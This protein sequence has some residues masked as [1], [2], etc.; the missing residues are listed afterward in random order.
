MRALLLV[1]VC[2]CGFIPALHAFTS[3]SINSREVLV[4]GKQTSIQTITY[5]ASSLDT[6]GTFQIGQCTGT[7]YANP[8]QYNYALQTVGNV[9]QSVI[10]V[11]ESVCVVTD[12]ETYRKTLNA[13]GE[14]L[15]LIY[16]PNGQV[17]YI[18]NSTG[19]PFIKDFVNYNT[20]TTASNPRLSTLP[21]LRYHTM[22]VGEEDCCRR[23]MGK[24]NHQLSALEQFPKRPPIKAIKD[25]RHLKLSYSK[26]YRDI[27]RLIGG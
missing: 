3:T 14:E 21:I 8:P 11:T 9:P 4:N 12:I 19:D 23:K 7:V 18:S 22:G 1:L 20:T 2:L 25:C 24:Y 10:P 5:T 15:D 13:Q 16:H 17:Q 6:H 27:I 26:Y